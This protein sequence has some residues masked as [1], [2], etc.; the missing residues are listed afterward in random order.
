MTWQTIFAWLERYAGT[1][2]DINEDAV[3]LKGPLAMVSPFE[4]YIGMDKIIDY[5]EEVMEVIDNY[6]DTLP[7]IFPSKDE[8]KKV[9]ANY[10]SDHLMAIIDDVKTQLNITP[11]EITTSEEL[12]MQMN[13]LHQFINMM[14]VTHEDTLA[15]TF[16][17]YNEENEMV[18]T[19]IF[20]ITEGDLT[21]HKLNIQDIREQYFAQLEEEDV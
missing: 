14:I 4:W 10:F 11:S 16:S 1:S 12:A 8:F 5:A 3:N 17:E 7:E 9:M 15:A 18:L 21:N 20:G 6:G 19:E 2:F 13:F